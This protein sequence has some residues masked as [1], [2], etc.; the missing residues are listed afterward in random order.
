MDVRLRKKI[1]V[2]AGRLAEQ[3]G[4]DRLIEAFYPVAVAH[5]EWELQIYGRGPDRRKLQKMINERGIAAQAHL[6]GW[7]DQLDAI[8]S[9]AAIFA[10]SSRFEGLPL[11]GIEA[12]SKGLPIVAFDCPRG[13]RELVRDGA[14]GYLVANGD[15]PAFTQALDRL[16]VD[17]QLRDAMGKASLDDARQYQMSAVG[18]QWEHLIAN[19]LSSSSR[20]RQTVAHRIRSRSA[21]ME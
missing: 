21:G 14:N 7:T 1:I 15:V 6:M 16:V 12:M 20:S 13:P 19:L 10:L 3:K 5:P 9:E 4:Y 18:E 17:A 8:L 2:A 11:V